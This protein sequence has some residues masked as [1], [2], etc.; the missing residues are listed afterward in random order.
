VW[1]CVAGGESTP[2]IPQA[3]FFC[4]PFRERVLAHHAAAAA[5][6]SSDKDT[7]LA[8]LG[9]L[10]AALAVEKR[11][12]QVIAPKRFVARLKRDNEAFRSCMHQDAHEFL[13]YLLNE[14]AEALQREKARE[15]EAGAVDGGEATA[16]TASTPT[17]SPPPTWVDDVFRGRLACETRCL[18]C[19]AT[20]ARDE[21]F[22]DLSLEVAPHVS[23]SACLKTFSTRE[24]LGGDDKFFCGACGCLQEAERRLRVA[25]LPPVLALHLKRFKYVGALDRMRKLAH[26]V[27]FPETLKLGPVA[28][29]GSAAADA[30]LRL[31]AVVVH[32]GA[33]PN[34]G[35][36]VAFVRGGGG[37]GG[38][39]LD[40]ETVEPA[41]AAAVAATFGSV[42]G[43]GV[44][45]GYI[46]LY[47][48]QDR[49][50]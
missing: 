36:Y 3:L 31:A 16:A 34:H 41:P 17:P 25:D 45:H 9:D 40:D 6:P 30:S 47:E 24:T 42:D 28:V 32:V 2:S 5:S 49:R 46:L 20:T 14:C 10:F 8:S 7:L 44:D 18:A 43:G 50:G 21:P 1:W 27:V 33:G 4:R 35:H 26:R 37:G 38:L 23:V 15:A 19:E 29:A 22:F 48:R 13:N 11:R 12:G 39:L